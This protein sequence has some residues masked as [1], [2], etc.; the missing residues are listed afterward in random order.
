MSLS[1]PLLLATTNPGKIR[2]M[3]QVLGPGEA[4]GV[5]WRT[6]RDVPPIPEPEES[7][8]TFLANARLKAEAYARATGLPTL[9]E[10][11]GLAIDALGGAPGIHSA[12]YPGRTYPEKFANLYAALADH[13]R[14]WTARYVCAVVIVS[15]PSPHRAPVVWSTEGTCDGEIWPTP[16]GD[17]GFGYDPIFYVPTWGRTFGEV[18]EEEKLTLA[19][20]GKAMRRV[21]EWLLAT[22]AAPLR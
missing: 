6:L 8:D 9:A 21:R 18:S 10:D 19:H 4:L 22:R 5:T 2:E 16:R 12:R 15:P 11:S 20:R 3:L 1:S 13:P 14:P 7:G 17:G